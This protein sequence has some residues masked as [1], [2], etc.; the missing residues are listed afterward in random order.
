MTPQ[1]VSLA[2]M[3]QKSSR[4]HMKDYRNWTV[5][6]LRY[7]RTQSV[8]LEFVGQTYYKEE[9]GCSWRGT[10]PTTLGTEAMTSNLIG[11]YKK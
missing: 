11:K 2:I 8:S 3:P 1:P 9:Q 5:V 7:T 10:C 4:A 6:L